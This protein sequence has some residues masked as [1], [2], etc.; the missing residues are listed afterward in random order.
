M[1]HILDNFCTISDQALDLLHNAGIY[2]ERD[3]DYVI[4]LEGSRTRRYQL[5][6]IQWPASLI[7][8]LIQPN[9]VQVQ[10]PTGTLVL[11]AFPDQP[12][13]V[14]VLQIGGPLVH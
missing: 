4:R 9:A 14:D 2:P 8:R 5:Y 12:V 11:F 10:L 13:M 7:A 6:A 1:N 3:N